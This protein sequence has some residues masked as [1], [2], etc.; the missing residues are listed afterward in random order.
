[1]VHIQVYCHWCC[2]PGEQQVQLILNHLTYNTKYKIVVYPVL[3][4]KHPIHLSKLIG[5]DE[6][7]EK[8]EEDEEEDENVDDF[9][10]NNNDVGDGEEN[11]DARVEE[12]ELEE[13]DGRNDTTEGVNED[14][15]VKVNKRDVSGELEDIDAVKNNTLEDRDEEKVVTDENNDVVATVDENNDDKVIKSDMNT[16]E[17]GKVIA[18]NNKDVTKVDDLNK[19]NGKEGEKILENVDGV[20]K[21][22]NGKVDNN[23][24]DYKN[25][26]TS[27]EEEEEEDD[28]FPTEEEDDDDG[29]K[30]EHHKYEF[31]DG[32]IVGVATKEKSFETICGSMPIK[33]ISYSF[34][35]IETSF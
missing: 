23:D 35:F 29:Y 28:D 22:E 7:D 5:Y 4:P 26:T 15:G 9:H 18:K 19:K 30:D 16:S 21:E 25:V 34:L 20:E 8:E 12:N 33:L 13:N 6:D 11:D 31:R 27:E 14:E 1:M 17:F 24:V 2:R 10:N 32:E 3:V